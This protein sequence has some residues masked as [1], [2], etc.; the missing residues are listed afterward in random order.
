[1]ASSSLKTDF[2]KFDGKKNFTF[3]QQWMKDLLVQ[4]R[5]Y[6]ILIR[7]GPKKISVKDWEELEKIAFSIIRMYF[8][9]EILPEI[10][11]EITPKGL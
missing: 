8:A 1:M 6:K 4:N 7:D 9:D 11:T 3:W 2:G 10:S 5:I